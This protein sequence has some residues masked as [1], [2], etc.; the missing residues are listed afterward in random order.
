MQ[1]GYDVPHF[2]KKSNS[3]FFWADPSFFTS[4]FYFQ[5]RKIKGTGE[6]WW[7]RLKDSDFVFWLD[8]LW[9][10]TFN[11]ETPQR[12]FLVQFAADLCS[13]LFLFVELRHSENRLEFSF[14]T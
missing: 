5:L 1:K 8:D 3:F 13:E 9:M 6:S 11:R 10:E 2:P 12:F 14:K 4:T 7:I